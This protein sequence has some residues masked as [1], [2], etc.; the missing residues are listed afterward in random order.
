[1]LRVATHFVRRAALFLVQDDTIQGVATEG[2]VSERCLRGLDS[3]RLSD[4]FLARSL[5][6]GS[7]WRGVPG[8]TGDDGLLLGTLGSV[9]PV[10]AATL[11]IRVVGRQVNLLYVDNESEVLSDAPLCSSAADTYERL[12]RELKHRHR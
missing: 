11:P 12:I 5:G 9:L 10:E 3:P 8:S 7:C 4:S 1:V 2:R 6:A